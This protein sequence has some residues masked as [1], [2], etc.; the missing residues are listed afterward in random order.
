MHV[1][2]KWN[3]EDFICIRGKED[4]DLARIAAQLRE[5]WKA[6]VVESDIQIKTYLVEPLAVETTQ[7][8]VILYKHNAFSLPILQEMQASTS[9]SP[10][11]TID[12]GNIRLDNDQELLRS[13]QKAL[14][15]AHFF[16]GHLR[17]RI[18]FGTLVIYNHRKADNE[19]GLQEFR[20]M[21]LHERVNARLLPG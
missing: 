14:S 18:H 6:A 21:M 3:L 8:E 2:M 16:A 11:K 17:M 13:F 19:Y 9:P 5:Q 12:L 1:F 10:P 15:K 20:E 7:D 4:T